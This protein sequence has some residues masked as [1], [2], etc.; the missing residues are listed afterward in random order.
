MSAAAES[1]EWVLP[2]PRSPI[3]LARVQVHQHLPELLVV[4]NP[5]EYG[6][7][8]VHPSDDRPHKQVLGSAVN[9]PM[10]KVVATTCVAVVGVLSFVV[11]V[12][13]VTGLT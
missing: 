12:Q 2:F 13:T 5:L 9:G 7:V 10:F 4:V 3:H 1:P 6:L 11:L 8:V